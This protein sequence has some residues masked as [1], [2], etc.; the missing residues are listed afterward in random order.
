MEATTSLLREGDGMLGSMVAEYKPKQ[1]GGGIS[2]M[3][4][5]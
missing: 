2:A 1:L 5:H 4:I 3:E